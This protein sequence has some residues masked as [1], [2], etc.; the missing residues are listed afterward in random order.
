MRKRWKGRNKEVVRG[1][2]RTLIG[3]YRRMEK[4]KS[5]GGNRIINRTQQREDGE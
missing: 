3:V 4:D 5:V 2:D 1:E